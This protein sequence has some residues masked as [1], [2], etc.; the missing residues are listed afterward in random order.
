MPF[1]R[2]Q[3]RANSEPVPP[4]ISLGLVRFLA[5]AKAENWTKRSAIILIDQLLLGR[6]SPDRFQRPSAKKC[7]ATAPRDRSGRQIQTK[8]EADVVAGG[9]SIRCEP[10][11]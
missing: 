3:L 10:L 4:P 7:R 5:S 9:S 6:K 11:G 2:W 8:A 1:Y